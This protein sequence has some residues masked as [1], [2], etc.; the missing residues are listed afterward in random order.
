MSVVVG[1]GPRVDG[2]VKLFHGAPFPDADGLLEV[3]DTHG[4]ADLPRHRWRA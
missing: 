1:D 3:E 4:E 2:L